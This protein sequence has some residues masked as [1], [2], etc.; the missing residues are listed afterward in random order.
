MFK[1]LFWM[2]VG[3][4]CG[5]YTVMKAQAYVKANTPAPARQ[6]LFGPDIDNV[7]LRTLQGMLQEF[8]IDLR[9]ELRA[10]DDATLARLSTL[11]AF[12]ESGLKA[13][14]MDTSSD[15]AA[16]G[17]APADDEESYQTASMAIQSLDEVGDGSYVIGVRD[18]DSLE[19]SVMRVPAGTP[20]VDRLKEGATNLTI[21]YALASEFEDDLDYAYDVKSIASAELSEDLS[22]VNGTVLAVADDE[23]SLSVGVCGKTYKFKVRSG[24]SV[25]E[26]G[27]SMWIC[28]PASTHF[29]AV[30]VRSQ[31][32]VSTRIA[33]HFSISSSTPMRGRPR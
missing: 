30:F 9:G 4:C 3:F 33:S 14:A 22:I 5:V 23:K 17:L 16:L 13:S 32:S 1:R 28:L 2:S 21:S 10:N 11:T 8:N 25:P 26:A 29:C 15:V 7:G 19:T 27:L 31:T 12:F 6:A 24:A 20:G 18:M